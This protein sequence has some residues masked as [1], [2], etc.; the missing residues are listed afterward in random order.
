MLNAAVLALENPAVVRH[1]VSYENMDL[2]QLHM[3][4]SIGPFMSKNCNCF[5][6][7]L[8]GSKIGK[9]CTLAFPNI[10]GKVDEN[11]GAA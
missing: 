6:N 2:D 9:V 11:E 10:N 4:L 3:G 7:Y 5:Q 1:H 8:A